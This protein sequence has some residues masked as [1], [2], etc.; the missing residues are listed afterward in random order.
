MKTPNVITTFCKRLL[1]CFGIFFLIGYLICFFYE[2]NPDF[3]TW[4][5]KTRYA[6]AIGLTSIMSITALII[7]IQISNEN[8]TSKW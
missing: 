8:S 2:A 4:E 3:S 7:A 6:M 1:Q 5:K